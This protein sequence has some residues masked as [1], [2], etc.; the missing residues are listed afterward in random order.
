MRHYKGSEPIKNDDIFSV[1]R[2]K[3]TDEFHRLSH[4]FYKA[5]TKL[6]R[7]SKQMYLK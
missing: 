3:P 6:I 7:N 1:K 2:G 4:S 5:K